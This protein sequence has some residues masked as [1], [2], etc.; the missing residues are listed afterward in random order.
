MFHLLDIALW[1]SYYITRQYNDKL[2]LIDF[3]E[4]LVTDLLNISTNSRDGRKLIKFGTLYEDIFINEMHFPELIP[5]LN[6]DG[7][8]FYK[9]C[10]VCLENKKMEKNKIYMQNMFK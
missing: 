10:K 2:T 9:R 5:N 6:N 8:S 3:R 4:Q 7:K 1:N